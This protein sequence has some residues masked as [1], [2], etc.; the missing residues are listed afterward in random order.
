[1]WSVYGLGERMAPEGLIFP[2][3]TWI[4]EFPKDI[5][6]IYF[7][8]DF[9][10]TIDPSVL[11]KVGIR[12]HDMFIQYLFYIPTPTATDYINLLEKHITKD[13]TVWADPSGETGGRGYISESRR[14]GFQVYAT[15]TFPGSIK[16]G[17]SIMHK[18]KIHVVDCPE[19]RKEFTGYVRA[20]AKVNGVMV[21]TDDPIDANNHGIDSTRM[22]CISNRL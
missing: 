10:Y 11:V 9:G 22:A 15:S 12:G 8:S 17:L 20:K 19:A 14:N 1:M 21:M 6:Q 4:N 13:S 3:I 18:Y 7:G 5:E 2:N 16:Y